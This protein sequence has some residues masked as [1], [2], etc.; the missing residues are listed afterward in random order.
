MRPKTFSEKWD[1]EENQSGK[2]YM[3]LSTSYG[4]WKQYIKWVIIAVIVFIIV[5]LLTRYL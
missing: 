3:P 5:G 2:G 4:G 1:R